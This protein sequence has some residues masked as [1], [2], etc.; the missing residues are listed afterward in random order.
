MSNEFRVDYINIDAVSIPWT[1]LH[2]SQRKPDCESQFADHE[3]CRSFVFGIIQEFV[4][5]IRT[6]PGVPTDFELRRNDPQGPQIQLGK[7]DGIV[8]AGGWYDSTSPS[9]SEHVLYLGQGDFKVNN[10][11]YGS[12]GFSRRVARAPRSHKSRSPSPYHGQLSSCAAAS[13][14]A[15]G[16]AARTHAKY[17]APSS[18]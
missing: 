3:L 11:R 14:F 16:V 12:V 4:N 13:A 9:S 5:Q 15:S 10:N 1:T 8:D 2:R 17:S 7:F 6:M 18:N